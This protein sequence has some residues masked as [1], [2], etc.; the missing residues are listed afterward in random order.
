MTEGSRV[1]P[2][3]SH[4]MSQPLPDSRTFALASLGVLALT[5]L[6]Y[7]PVH[8]AGFAWDDYKFLLDSGWMTDR[9][10]WPHLL[11]HGFPEWAS[12]YRPLGIGLFIAETSMSS[13]E[14]MPMHLLSLGI[15]LLNMVLIGLLARRLLWL[16]APE[17][18]SKMETVAL[19]G[20]AMLIYGVHPALTEP[21]VWI[22]AQ[23]DMLTTC[24]ILAGLVLNF[25]LRR[26]ATR[27][28]CVALCFLL[29]ALSK[30]AALSFPFILFVLDWMMSPEDSAQ[31]E[32]TTRSR[33]ADLLTRQWPIYA[34]V[35]VAGLAYLSLRQWGTGFLINS[36]VKASWSFW[37]QL[38][39]ACYTYI[40]YWKLLVWP[41]GDLGPIHDVAI[42]QFGMF[43]PKLLA[44]DAAALVI[45]WLGLW[46]LWKRRI[47]GGVIASVSA[48]LLPVL[49]IIPHQFAASLYHNRYAMTAIAM[50]CAFLPLACRASGFRIRSYRLARFVPLVAIVWLILAMVNTRICIPLWSSD[51]ALWRW[52]LLENPR[53]IVA[54]QSLLAAYMRDNDY[55]R[56]QPLA[57]AMVHGPARTCF[58]CMLN[59]A[60]LRIATNDAEGASAALKDAKEDMSGSTTRRSYLRGYMLLSGQLAELQHNTAEA[61]EAYRAVISFEPQL[62]EGYMRL[63][64]VLA[65]AQRFD[66]ARRLYD[67]ALPL[68]APAERGH[69]KS[70]FDRLLGTSPPR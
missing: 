39:T 15:H 34:A 47:L 44:I 51:T 23:F 50:A 26:R 41:M 40:A 68:Y 46:L 19:P 63:A 66:E 13:F 38:Q 12:Y 22:S 36:A 48:A 65:R 14:P 58:G 33:L 17:A 32:R 3:N 52:A 55:P 16:C 28:A 62:P 42:D 53:S 61:E 59:V 21:V 8:A 30:E 70:Q 7:W 60:A 64:T 6:V 67:M 56:A 43:S 37:P 9:S 27:A 20:L 35:F 1:S 45:A 10:Y 25:S 49:H 24:F 18:T 29:S 31:P 57:D 69:I 11:A 54:Q 4:S 5:C 2:P